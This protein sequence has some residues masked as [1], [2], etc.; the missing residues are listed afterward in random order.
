MLTLKSNSVEN[1]ENI[2]QKVGHILTKNDIL[3]LNGE[4][5]VGKTAFVRGILKGVGGSADMVT[6]PSYTYLNIYEAPIKVFHMD[7]YLLHSFSDVYELGYEELYNNGLIVMEWGDKFIAEILDP[8][9]QINISYTDTINERIIKIIPPKT[10]KHL[11]KELKI[12]G[13]LSL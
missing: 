6:S 13:N 11:L 4:L 1:T 10:K 9:W 7:V 12:S 2:A 5:G 3:L 8:Y